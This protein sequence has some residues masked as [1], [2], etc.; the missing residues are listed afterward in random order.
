MK[1]LLWSL[2]TSA[3]VLLLATAYP[4]DASA[5]LQFGEPQPVLGGVNGSSHGTNS[6]EGSSHQMRQSPPNRRQTGRASSP[7]P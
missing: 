6:P 4:M 3:I 7:R 2:R 1:I 5:Q